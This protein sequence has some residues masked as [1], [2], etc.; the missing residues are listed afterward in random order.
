MAEREVEVIVQIAEEDVVAGRLWTHRRQQTES[1]TFSYTPEYV[2]RRDAY[3]LDPVLELREGPHQTPNGRAIFGAF[4]DCAPDRWGRRL[5]ARNESRRAAR[6]GGAERSFGETDYLL[7]VRDDL[8]QGALRFRDP[9]SETFLADEATGIPSL[10]ELPKLLN[11]ADHLE[12]DEA[13]DEELATLLRGGS[14]LGG[15]RPKAHAMDAS[16]RLAIAKFPSAAA[17]NWDVMRWEA[18][19]LQL[20]SDAGIRVPASTLHEIDGKAVLIVDR[21]DRPGDRR[22]GYCS[23][24]TMLERSNGDRGSYLEIAE[25]IEGESPHA[26]D[27]LHELWRRIAFSILVSNTDDHLRNHGFLRTSSAGWSLSPAFD[28]NP[29]PRPGAKHLNT[30][31]NDDDTAARVDLLLNVADLFR[32]GNADDA[33]TVLGQVSAAAARWRDVASDF[34]LDRAALAQ[35]KPAFEHDQATEAR[36]L[37]G[38]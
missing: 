37:V 35:M 18:V 11:A 14:S 25:A 4:S 28:L 7:G 29:D 21:F 19:A 3:A 27:D 10:I 5:I 32:L 31:I 26:Q 24:M 22:I 20:A 9:G 34:G 13:T 33:V 23:A 30:A 6:E 15:A 36:K 38:S 17:D 12:R 8:R 16:G 2:E 1:Q